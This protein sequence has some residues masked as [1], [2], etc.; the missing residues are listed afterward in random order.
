MADK[1]LKEEGFSG[2]QFDGTQSVMGRKAW[3]PDQ[4][5]AGYIV[6]AVRKQRANR[7]WGLFM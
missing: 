1:Q 5:D 4:E 7:T 6:S 2:S 3:Q